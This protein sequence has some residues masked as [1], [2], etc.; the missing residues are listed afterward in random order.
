MPTTVAS[1]FRI[2]QDTSGAPLESGYVYLG[3][4]NQNPE[5]NPITAYWDSALTIAA[6]LPIRTVGGYPSRFGT[7]AAV[8]VAGAY[9]ITVKD[10]TSRLVFTAPNVEASGA[11]VLAGFKNY[12]Q[13]PDFEDGT[14]T[15]WN[16]GKD[17]GTTTPTSGGL[18]AGA[19]GFSPLSIDN[20]TPLA[21]SASMVVTKPTGNVQGSTVYS[22][23]LAIDLEDTVSQGQLTF[24]YRTPAVATYTSGDLSV[25]MWDIT[26]GA[27]I[28]LS[29]NTLDVS[30]SLPK[31]FFATFTPTTSKLYRIIF[32][33]TSASNLNA[34]QITLD[35]ILLGPSVTIV[36]AATVGGLT[37][38]N[39]QK[40][41]VEKSKQVGEV[42]ALIDRKAPV[43]WASNPDTYFPAV[44]LSDINS[45]TDV[46]DTSVPD[47]VTT[48]RATKSGYRLGMAGAKT[49]FDVTGWAIVANVITLT[50]ANTAAE[51]AFLLSLAEDQTVH[52]SFTG[53]RSVTTSVALGGCPAG[54]YAITGINAVARTLTFSYTTANASGGAITAE[55][56]AN[57]VAG[58]TTTARLFAV[59][60]RALVAANDS[61]DEVV[62]GL[63][64]RDRVQGHNHAPNGVAAQFQLYTTSS[65]IGG[66]SGTLYR[67]SSGSST[68][69]LSIV[70]DGTNGP[71]RPGPTTDPR[72]LGVHLYIHAG[73]KLA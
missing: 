60:G 28:P 48:L 20:V 7:P 3:V 2:F 61:A 11:V 33:W 70:T 35:S 25:F 65:Y 13:A 66:G 40:W 32:Q 46:A 17:F 49:S 8:Y 44:C 29:V 57:R 51:I 19:S 22:D 14:T 42:F 67:D 10:K 73:R 23:P 30:T 24:S 56:Y 12:V 63:R 69:P 45:Y 72:A 27:L 31:K 68:P 64:R 1:P 41:S 54:D 16:L 18:G 55:F 62:A 15:G 5:T 58:S 9:S 36:D 47:L 43:A 26:G 37:L 34:V 39:L 4:A 50:F 6:A 53:W 59:Q 38:V 71:P 52:G 21:G